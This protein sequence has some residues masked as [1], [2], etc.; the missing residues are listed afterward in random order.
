MHATRSAGWFFLLICLLA[1]CDSD[2]QKDNTESQRF[3]FVESLSLV[4]SAGVQLQD[5]SLSAEAVSAA[6]ERM[7]DGLKMAFEVKAEFLDRY[8]PRL[9]KNYQRY[10]VKGIE[11][12]RLGIEAG[13]ADEQ[14]SGL[15]LLAQWADFWSQAGK[16]ILTDMQTK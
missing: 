6:L 14:K 8:D 4:E 9:S 11:S 3:Y 2:R 7:D 12:Y 16:S 10:F 13:D 1:A 15:R 5:P